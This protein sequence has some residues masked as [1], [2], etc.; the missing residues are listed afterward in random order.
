[1][2]DTSGGAAAAANAGGAAAGADVRPELDGAPRVV[3]LHSCL[4]KGDALGVGQVID[5][6]VEYD[7]A[8]TVRDADG[9]E[10]G[11]TDQVEPPP[12]DGI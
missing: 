6:I 3:A 8:V 5:V 10:R 4:P 2:L 7:A 9:A 1:M 12:D 11:G